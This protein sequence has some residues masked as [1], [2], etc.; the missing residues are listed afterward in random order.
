MA[1]LK[2]EIR[3]HIGVL[4][5]EIDQILEKH[6]DTVISEVTTR[7]IFGGMRGLIAMACNTSYVDPYSGL[8]ISG[9]TAPEF[10]DKLPEEIFFLLCTGKFPEE[11]DLI[12][13]QEDLKKRTHIPE[14]TWEVL[15]ALPKDTHPM[16]MLSL[17]ILSMEGNSVF[18]KKYQEGLPKSEFWDATLEDALDLI[19]KLPSLAA[20]I[21][22][23]R[24]LD[25]KLIPYNPELDW[26]GNMANML[27]IP[28]AGEEFADLIRLYLVLHCDHEGGNVSAF[29]SRVVSSALSNIYYA[30]SAGLNGLAG[31]LHGLANQ[32][33]LRF[34]IKVHEEIGAYP[35]EKE[36]EDY[37]NKTL[38]SGKVIPGYGHAVLRATDPRFVAFMEFGD[39]FCSS[40]EYFQIV[41]KLFSVVPRVLKTYKGGKVANPWPNVDAISGS[42][43]YHYG[44]D[45]FD[46]YTVM[47]GVSRVLGF[48][49]QDILARGLGQ[50][51]IRPKSVTNRWLLQK[52]DE[53]STTPAK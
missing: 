20:G 6:K 53:V 5:Q 40:N 25:G 9:I 41:K 47:F 30:S 51:I 38:D 36:L 8:H 18:K 45:N 11:K 46:Y 34:I 49:A 31:P 39:K 4:K 29:T 15:R 26:A 43:L 42:L 14:Y 27:G 21:Y 32:E 13:L 19:A 3:L 12:L 23:I 1:Q 17:G 16:T 10:S 48:C 28:G 24:F 2:E 52:L 35:S 37:V 50:P 33:C 7:Q 44:V 22:R